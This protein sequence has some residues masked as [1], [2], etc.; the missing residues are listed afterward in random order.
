MT[1]HFI[2]LSSKEE[3]AVQSLSITTSSLTTHFFKTM[4]LLLV[5]A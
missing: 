4:R 5:A 3:L 2:F 1:N